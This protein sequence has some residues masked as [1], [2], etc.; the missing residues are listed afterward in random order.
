MN[1]LITTSNYSIRVGIYLLPMLLNLVIGL[2]IVN[3]CLEDF[4]I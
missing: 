2:T 1:Y 4:G 3:M